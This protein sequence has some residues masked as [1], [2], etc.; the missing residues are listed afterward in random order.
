[1]KV[2]VETTSGT[3]SLSDDAKY[4]YCVSPTQFEDW[5]QG[6]AKFV[7]LHLEDRTSVVRFCHQEYAHT[8]CVGVAVL[9]E[10]LRVVEVHGGGYCH[11]KEGKWSFSGSSGYFGQ[12]DAEEV[13]K[14]LGPLTEGVIINISP[15]TCSRVS[16]VTTTEN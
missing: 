13:R 7:V 5:W 10:G 16:K 15:S 4:R 8:A 6:T 12:Y 2:C 1:M 11:A 9:Y 14:A 3:Q